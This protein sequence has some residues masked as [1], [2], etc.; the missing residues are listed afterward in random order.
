MQN[1]VK[2]D[3]IS[4]CTVSR[5]RVETFFSKVPQQLTESTIWDFLTWTCEH[6]SRHLAMHEYLIYSTLFLYWFSSSFLYIA[7]FTFTTSWFCY[8]ISLCKQLY[9]TINHPYLTAIF[10]N[11]LIFSKSSLNMDECWL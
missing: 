5:L 9:M 2:K 1:W 11:H 7:F 10:C 6:A 4:V 8:L 3:T